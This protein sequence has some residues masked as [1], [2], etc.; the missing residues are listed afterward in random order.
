[1]ETLTSE[2][3]KIADRLREEMEKAYPYVFTNPYAVERFVVQGWLRPERL[4][5]HLLYDYLISQGFCEVEE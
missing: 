2:Q 4:T 3:R 5:V 1:M